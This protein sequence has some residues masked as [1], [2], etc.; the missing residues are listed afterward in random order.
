MQTAPHK[1]DFPYGELRTYGYWPRKKTPPSV[2]EGGIEWDR[3]IP[4]SQIESTEA[5]REY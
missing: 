1:D 3:A 5:Y 4:M 2:I